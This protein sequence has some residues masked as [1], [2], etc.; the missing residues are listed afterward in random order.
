MAP[1]RVILLFSVMLALAVADPCPP[2]VSFPSF[3]QGSYAAVVGNGIANLTI[4]DT[5]A[6]LTF[7]GGVRYLA[8]LNS[9]F[10]HTTHPAEYNVK[11]CLSVPQGNFNQCGLLVIASSKSYSLYMYAPRSSLSFIFLLA[12]RP[13]PCSIVTSSI[14]TSSHIYRYEDVS[15]FGL[16][17]SSPQSRGLVSYAFQRQN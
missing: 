7:S 12:S 6:S 11:Y 3:I 17:P 14:V 4:D 13:P 1:I 16:C 10:E 5:S 9:P 15:M 2:P 8:T